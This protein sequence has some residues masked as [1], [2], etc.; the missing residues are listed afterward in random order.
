[1]EKAVAANLKYAVT[2]FFIIQWYKR[3]AAYTSINSYCTVKKHEAIL[4][5]FE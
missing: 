2:A 3:G 5:I 1:M 4:V